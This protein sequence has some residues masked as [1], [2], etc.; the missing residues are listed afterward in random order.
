MS[1]SLWHGESV[2]DT[3]DAEFWQKGKD[4]DEPDSTADSHSEGKGDRD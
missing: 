4:S 1:T 3:L 2:K